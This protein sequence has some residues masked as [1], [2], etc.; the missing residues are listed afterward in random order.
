[1]N[2]QTVSKARHRGDI[3][4]FTIKANNHLAVSGA[5][6]NLFVR[7][8]DWIRENEPGLL[9]GRFAA[10][11]AS[12][13]GSVVDVSASSSGNG[14][15]DSNGHSASGG[16]FYKHNSNNKNVNNNQLSISINRFVHRNPQQ[17]QQP[18]PQQQ[19]QFKS[20]QPQQTSHQKYTRTDSNYTGEIP[21]GLGE[22]KQFNITLMVNDWIRQQ[23]HQSF[24]SDLEI[25]QEVVV[26]TSEPWMRQLLVLDT[27]SQDVSRAQIHFYLKH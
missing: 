22:W 4:E 13:D 2:A 26:K 5:I 10:A 12:L 15:D 27:G 23:R 21:K 8:E 14:N 20:Q 16:S 25:V 3:L 6:F 9:K 11:G 1:M 19:Q 24:D 17:Q 7:G 18:Q